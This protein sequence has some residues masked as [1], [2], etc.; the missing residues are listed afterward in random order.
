MKTFD[1]FQEDNQIREHVRAVDRSITQI[2][3]SMS[4]LQRLYGYDTRMLQNM[5]ESFKVNWQDV[6][7][8]ILQDNNPYR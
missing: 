6:M 7:D 4:D 1:Q 5:I 8:K 3:I 2:E